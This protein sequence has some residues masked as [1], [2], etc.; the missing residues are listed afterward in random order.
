[1]RKYNIGFNLVRVIEYLYDKAINA[2]IFNGSI[3]DW[4][5]TTVG[6]RQGLFN[7]F[8]ERIDRLENH[9]GAVSIGGRTFPLLMTKRRK[10]LAN[11]RTAPRRHTDGIRTEVKVSGPKLEAWNSNKLQVPGISYHRW[12][13]Q[14]WL[15]Y[16]PGGTNMARLKP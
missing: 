2:V 7:I 4:L 6:V 12:G 8:L 1:M 14:T 9:E 5:R 15:R 11:Q 16:L 3:G 13:F 10:E